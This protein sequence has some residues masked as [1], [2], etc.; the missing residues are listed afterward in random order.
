MS[1]NVGTRLGSLEITALLGKGGMGEVYRA[2]DAKLKREV[3]IKILPDEFSRDADRVN[4]FQ[5]EAE[6]LASLSHPN[7]AGIYDLQQTDE[8][9]FL[10]M[11][12]VNGETLADR[13]ARGP[14]PVDEALQIA[15]S[16]ADALEAAHERGV[17]HRDLKPSNVKITPDGKV[18]VLDFGLAKAMESAPPSTLSNSPT[19]VSMAATNAGVILGT[20]AYMSPE[21]AKG[22]TVDRRTDIWALGC[23]VYESLTA[24]PA[25][26]GDSTAE[27]LGNVLKTEPDWSALPKNTTASIVAL[28]RRCL[29][30]DVQQRPKDAG[31]LRLELEEA[32]TAFLSAAST[33]RQAPAPAKRRGL[34]F[35][36]LAC[37]A[38]AAL[39]AVIVLNLRPAS[40]TTGPA[41]QRMTIGLRSNAQL[42]ASPFEMA[43]LS[44][45]GS[46]LVYSASGG[47]SSLQLYL[48]AMD[49]LEANA[50]AGTE[51]AVSPFF[52]PDGQWIGF[53]AGGNLKKVSVSG[54]ATLTLCAAPL[55]LGGTWLPN[56]TI[57]FNPAPGQGLFQVAAA[58]GVPQSLTKLG[59]GEGGHRWP[60]FLPGGKAILYSVQTSSTNPDD[61][62]IVFQRLGSAE[63]QILIRGGTYPR[64]VPTGHLVYYRAGT[65]MAVAFDP[66][67]L[68]VKGTPAPV[69]E[70]VRSSLSGTGAGQFSFSNRGS[71]VYLPGT[72]QSANVSLVWVDRHGAAQPLAAPSRSYRAP[73][74]SPDGRQIAVGIGPDV[75]IYNILR[76]TLTRLTFEKNNAGYA[77]V[78]TPDS[79]R[80][81]FPSDRAGSLNIFW[82][83][84]DG[85]SAEERLTTSENPQQVGSFSPDGRTMLY[86]ETNP[87][88]RQDIWALSLDGERKPHVFLAT[89]FRESSALFSPDGHW[90]AYLSDES[91]RIEVYVRP[92]PGPGGKWQVSVDGGSQAVWSSK[93]NELFYRTGNSQEKMMV[94]DIQTQPTF[95]AGKPR[96]LFEGSYV[97]GAGAA[98]YSA[99]PDG[100][101]FLMSKT[102]DQVQASLTEFNVVV[103][104]FTELQR[105]VPVK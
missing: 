74:L 23:I 79:K 61:D 62:N 11:E 87:K 81:A 27:I 5:R 51:G 24:E 4:R 88:T 66:Q 59:T 77:A 34:L 1:V 14:I 71:L 29:R 60:Q 92:F 80:V 40:D 47:S 82:K 43:A 10:V 46:H 20:A 104:W 28:L 97:G 100:Q 70:G 37:L 8:T 55:P 54:G 95:S 98:M 44:P 13:I 12:L 30:K 17:I 41:V 9:R 99:S 90:V 36:V 39:T 101:R 78:W 16:I 21:Q 86:T 32:R 105:R 96:L 48:R 63:H 72:P 25:F 67:K 103:N 49:S 93:G 76:D 58:G 15:K 33:V 83:A 84:A 35:S 89:P 38:V 94:V 56:D 75:W 57:V 65:I 53:F 85:S 19:I 26:P 64:Y 3:A 31:D 50:I 7:I 91:G 42:V 68:E 22:K 45:D 52:S 18:K 69:Q 73:R 6:V 102:P 2:R